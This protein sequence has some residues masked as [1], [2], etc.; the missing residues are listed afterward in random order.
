[1]S[2]YASAP[3]DVWSLGVILVNLTCGRNPWKRASLED[4]TFR[5]YL[6]DPSF[7]KTI[8]PLSD[9]MIFILSR[10]F[11][12]DPMKRITI[13]EL[14]G[15]ILNCPRLTIPPWATCAG[16]QPVEVIPPV[17][18]SVPVEPINVQPSSS[19]SNSSHYSHYSDFSDSAASDAS[20]I[21]EDYDMDGMSSVS[22]GGRKPE[23]AAEKTVLPQ[24]ECNMCA[25]VKCGDVPVMP[26]F[27]FQ[28]LGTLVC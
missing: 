16:P 15:L 3:N 5:A 17:P 12:C 25:P 2:C 22:S 9:E 8:L 19:S 28:P 7:L 18:V 21:T 1:M 4:A 14:R 26:V 20:A 13:P 11:E 6:K 10:I 24:A 27:P 23:V